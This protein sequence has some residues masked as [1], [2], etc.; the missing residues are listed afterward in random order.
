MGF[1]FVVVLVW[2]V[3]VLGGLCVSFLFQVCVLFRHRIH[4]NVP[5][6]YKKKK[7]EKQS[8]KRITWKEEEEGEKSRVV[9]ERPP[10]DDE[11]LI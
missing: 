2:F 6:A 8:F 7:N 1:G 9:H 4:S 11:P 10:K 3:V 5:Y